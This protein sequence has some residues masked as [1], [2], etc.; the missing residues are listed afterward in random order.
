MCGLKAN[1]VTVKP[2][3]TYSHHVPLSALD[4]SVKEAILLLLLRATCPA[5]TFLDFKSLTNSIKTRLARLLHSIIS[6]LFSL[7]TFPM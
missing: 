2:A 4:V 5:T 6:I 3:G 1:S 7:R